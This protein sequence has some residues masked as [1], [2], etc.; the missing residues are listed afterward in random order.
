MPEI[1][2][3]PQTTAPSHYLRRALLPLRRE[4]ERKRERELLIVARSVKRA[5][6]R[7]MMRGDDRAT[8]LSFLPTYLST[9]GAVRT[10]SGSREIL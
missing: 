1:C 9:C 2:G 10:L 6:R 5:K 7:E 8:L 3:F 4:K